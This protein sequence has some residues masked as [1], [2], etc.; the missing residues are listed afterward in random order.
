MLSGG[1]WQ[2]EI[3]VERGTEQD[4]CA[5]A[6]SYSATGKQTLSVRAHADQYWWETAHLATVALPGVYTQQIALRSERWQS[7]RLH[8]S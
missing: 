1:D 2:L 3:H 6:G 5:V 8:L 7:G 4:V